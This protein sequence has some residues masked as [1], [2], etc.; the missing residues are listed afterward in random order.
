MKVAV[1]DKNNNIKYFRFNGRQLNKFIEKAKKDIEGLTEI[2]SYKGIE[3]NK[4][5]VGIFLETK[6]V[7]KK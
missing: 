2:W 4:S 3:N 1:E 5:N 6:T 7:F